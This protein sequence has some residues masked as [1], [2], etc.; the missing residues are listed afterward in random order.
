MS[1]GGGGCGGA[2]PRARC[3]TRRRT[4]HGQAGRESLLLADRL[5]RLLPSPMRLTGLC[6]PLHRCGTSPDVAE[7]GPDPL[8]AEGGLARPP[9]LASAHGIQ[10]SLSITLAGLPSQSYATGSIGIIEKGAPASRQWRSMAVC[11]IF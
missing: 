9:D 2:Q 11:A 4:S 10:P 3:S 5:P 6:P 8:V 7:P 1:G